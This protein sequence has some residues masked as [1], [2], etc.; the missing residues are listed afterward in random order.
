MYYYDKIECLLL[1]ALISFCFFFRISVS[2]SNVSV[3]ISNENSNPSNRSLNTN[4]YERRTE[5]HKLRDTTKCYSNSSH[6]HES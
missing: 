5:N 3:R 6:P 1:F 2:Q 4:P